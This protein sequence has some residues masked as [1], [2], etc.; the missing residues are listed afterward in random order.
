M[1]DQQQGEIL[2]IETLL[3]QWGLAGA[4]RVFVPDNDVNKPMYL[5]RYPGGFRIGRRCKAVRVRAD[6][7][8]K[9]EFHRGAHP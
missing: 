5:F 9:I 3:R 6:Y 1:N 8:T 4:R 7:T 2:D